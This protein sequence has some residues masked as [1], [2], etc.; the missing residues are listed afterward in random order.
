MI[1]GLLAASRRAAFTVHHFAL[2]VLAAVT[3]GAHAAPATN[4]PAGIQLGAEIVVSAGEKGAGPRG[5][6][7]VASG[8]GV[9]LAAWRE[10]WQG[11]GGAARI[12]VARVDAAGKLLDAKGVVVAPDAPGVQDRPRVAFGGGVFLVV[13]QELADGR[14]YDLKAVRV[15]PE[16]KV[17][18]PKPFGVA[19]GPDNEVMADVASDGQNFLVVWQGAVISGSDTDYQVLA[20]TV[21]AA[22]AA[23]PAAKLFGG[24]MA[25][26]AWDGKYYLVFGNGFQGMRLDAG[27]KPVDKSFRFLWSGINMSGVVSLAGC[28][29]GGWLAVLERSQPDYWGWG[30]PGAM[31]CRQITPELALAADQAAYHKENKDALS[32]PK[33]ILYDDWLDVSG[34]KSP[35]SPWPCGVSATCWDGK[36]F[37]VAWQRH[38]IEKSVMFVN[39]DVMASRVN[40]WRPLDRAGV[41]VAASGSE[42]RAP[43]LASDGAGRLLCVYE[44]LSADGSVAI[45]GRPMVTQ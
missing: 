21:S 20:A 45:C 8:Q 9:Y 24:G 2:V 28:G 16:G 44:K 32:A 18:D 14:Q 22:G 27:G 12:C 33:S 26:A 40:G 38:H 19:A 35:G 5:E 7:A 4:D 36:Q 41:P 23:A 43:A 39:C 3:L 13:W 11:E 1:T 42:E 31:I 10:G 34:N 17:L 30:G 29:S 37:V 15:S 6:P 25:H